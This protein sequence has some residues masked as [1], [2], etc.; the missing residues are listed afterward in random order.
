[1]ARFELSEEAD[2]D[3]TDIYVYTYKQFSPAQA[4]SYLKNLDEIFHFLADYPRVGRNMGLDHPGYFRYEH[5]SHVIF[6][7]HQSTGIFVV[8]VLHQSMDPEQH[9]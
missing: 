9:L 2:L 3:L 5:A 7:K 4:E 6:Y 8:R 1:M